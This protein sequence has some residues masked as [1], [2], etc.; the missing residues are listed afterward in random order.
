METKLNIK[1]SVAAVL[2][3]VGVGSVCAGEESVFFSEVPTVYS[4]SRMPQQQSET[5]NFVTVID[6]EMIRA[7]G[8]RQVTDLMRL[9]PGFQVT[10]RGVEVPARVAYHG[11][12]NDSY[13]PRMQVLIDGKSQ[14]SPLFQGGVNWDLLPVAIEE[15]E[16]IEVVRGANVAA[17]GTNA[18]MGVVNIITVDPSLVKGTTVATAFGSNGV[19]DQYVSYGGKSGEVALR[20]T[21]KAQEDQGSQFSR[22]AKNTGKTNP[23][24]DDPVSIA[25]AWRNRLFDLNF[26]LPINLTDELTVRLSAM[27]GRYQNGRSSSQEF[28]NKLYNPPR[29]T[30]MSTYQAQLD[31]LRRYVDGGELLV[32]FSS[33][34][35]RIVDP[36]VSGASFFVAPGNDTNPFPIEG[37]GSSVRHSLEVQRISNL[38][39]ELRMVWGLAGQS[40][41]IDHPLNFHAGQA[42]RTTGRIFSTAEWKAN[43]Q[44]LFNFGGSWDA[45]SIAGPVFSPRVNA[46]YQLTKNHTLRAGIVSAYR[47]PSLYEYKGWSHFGQPNVLHYID[48]DIQTQ[49]KGNVDIKPER[50]RG[51]EVGYF[52]DLTGVNATLDVRLFSERVSNRLQVVNIKPVNLETVDIEGVEYQVQWRPQESTRVIFGQSM[53][54]IKSVLADP[55]ETGFQSQTEASAPNLSSSLM[56]MQSLPNALKA[57]V[58]VYKVD[59]IRWAQDYDLRTPAYTRVD[60]RLAKPFIW[61]T[62]RGEVAYVVQS[63][64]GAHAELKPSN[65]VMP[66]QWVSIRFDL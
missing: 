14:Y 58:V 6:Q 12:A 7:S 65:M 4:S 41:R 3:C 38:G 48:D 31:W 10:S 34:E 44:W 47:V 59:A 51:Y 25:N 36:S 43:Q 2:V 27:E 37:S 55:N 66:R 11:L 35:D 5:P 26:G 16:R 53:V 24:D 56:L 22:L 49:F 33:V 32:R 18:F 17:Y 60:W 64:E 15:I 50:M 40:E 23:L 63:E 29:T 42:S 39:S 20:L 46:N 45:D 52:G 13:S 57:S 1:L 21:Y 9:V 30:G 61:G 54:T 19:Q 8:A 28:G 62:T